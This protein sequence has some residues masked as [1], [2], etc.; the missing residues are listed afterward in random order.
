[1]IVWSTSFKY[2][3]VEVLNWNNREITT[4]LNG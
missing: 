2:K 1:M 4:N 3:N